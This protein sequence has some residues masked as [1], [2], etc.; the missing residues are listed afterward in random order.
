M[1]P[2]GSWPIVAIKSPSKTESH[3]FH[4]VLPP[5]DDATARPKNTNA[6]ISGGPIFMIAHLASGSVALIIT[7]A[8]ATPPIA[9]QRT[10]APTALP[11]IPF[12]VIGYPSNAVGAFSGAPG[13]LN[14]IAVMA[15]P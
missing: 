2:T 1:P 11:A 6:K 10:A 9:E 8:E 3:P 13:I 14:K 12:C 5:T 4:I 7:K 15:P